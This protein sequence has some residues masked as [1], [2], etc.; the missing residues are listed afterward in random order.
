MR[1]IF[2]SH[3]EGTFTTWDHS[4]ALAESLSGHWTETPLECSKRFLF[5]LARLRLSSPGPSGIGES[6]KHI[7][8]P[9][10]RKSRRAFRRR[11]PS[12]PRR[13]CQRAVLC[14]LAMEPNWDSSEMD[15]ENDSMEILERIWF[16][17]RFEFSKNRERS[18]STSWRLPE[19][20]KDLATW[21]IKSQKLEFRKENDFRLLNEQRN[22]KS[23]NCHYTRYKSIS[24]MLITW[25]LHEGNCLILLINLKRNV[26]QFS[27][28][29]SIYAIIMSFW[30]LIWS[31][32]KNSADLS[33]KSA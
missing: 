14:K 28:I 6:R 4:T 10:C 15:N 25:R 2:I 7:W 11:S 1:R 29:I 30:K 22:L 19:N 3:S 20:S 8:G 18:L 9:W 16:G 12:H 21:I 13:C 31:F 27:L 5:P 23:S 26:N 24:A 32:S 17:G 33:L